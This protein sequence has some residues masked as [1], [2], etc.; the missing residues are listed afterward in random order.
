V[1]VEVKKLTFWQC[2]GAKYFNINKKMC[3]NGSDQ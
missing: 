2:D 3:K 1:E